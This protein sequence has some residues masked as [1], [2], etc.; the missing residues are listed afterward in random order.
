MQMHPIKLLLA[1]DHVII[2]RGL[3]VMI[4]NHFLKTPIFEADTNRSVLRIL[5]NEAITHAIL[6]MQ[7]QDGNILEVF[8]QIRQLYPQ[9]KVLVYT[10]N[11]EEIYGP[12]MIQMGASG[13]LSKNSDEAEVKKALELFFQG[14]DYLSTALHDRLTEKKQQKESPLELLSEREMSVLNRLLQGESV[15]EISVA[16][17]L[18]ATTVATYKARLFEK[19]LVTN[20]IDLRKVVELYQHQ[21]NS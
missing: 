13:F 3:K 5:E 1:D 8:Q 14:R 18:K 9:I 7:L 12:R 2:R 11:A 15:K 4:D 20:I 17:D 6:D 16:L 21:R 10:M 19:L